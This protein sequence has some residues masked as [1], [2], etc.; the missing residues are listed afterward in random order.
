MPRVTLAQAK[1]SRIA[2]ALGYC[3][4]SDKFLATLNEAQ[5][6]L[7]SRG[8][9]VGTYGQFN[10]AVTEGLITWPREIETVEGI[11]ICDKPIP[12]KNEWFEFSLAGPGYHRQMESDGTSH[13]GDCRAAIYDRG[14]SPLIR[15]IEG[16]RQLKVYIDNAADV[17]KEIFFKAKDEDGNR[18]YQNDGEEGFSVTMASPF[19]LDTTTVTEVY[20]VIKAPTVGAV[21]VYQYN[22][23]DA[24]QELIAVYAPG[25]TSPSYRRTFLPNVSDPADD[26]TVQVMAKLAFIPAQFDT[27]F[28]A[29]SS[30]PALKEM[31]VAVK[32]QEC[33]KWMEAE[34]SEA[35][36]IRELE[37]QLESYLGDSSMPTLQVSVGADLGPAVQNLI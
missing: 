37:K 33:E 34:A 2:A 1:A 36:A 22:P 30:I 35:R 10:I 27:D 24:S 18:I 28:L 9:W 5:E 11:T 19:V 31:C 7:L 12:L 6:R 8:K 14:T 26:L 25:E 15:D 16:E 20:G 21:R 32:M 29:I 4:T 13:R 17:G 3:A 23:S